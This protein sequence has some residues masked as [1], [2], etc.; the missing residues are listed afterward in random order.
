MNTCSC[1]MTSCDLAAVL[2]NIPASVDSIVIQFL[3]LLEERASQLLDAS[4]LIKL[5]FFTDLTDHCNVFFLELQGKDKII[6]QI[7][8]SLNTLKTKLQSLKSQLR[9]GILKNFYN[10]EK[11]FDNY[12]EISSIYDTLC[13]KVP[14]IWQ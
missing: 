9:K 11:A 12:N 8:I 3:E 10:L 5:A 14:N 13:T 2:R 6:I 4:L 7:I 1:I